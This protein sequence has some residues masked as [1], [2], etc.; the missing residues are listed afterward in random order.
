MMCCVLCYN[1]WQCKSIIAVRCSVLQCVAVCCSMLYWSQCGTHD[2]LPCDTQTILQHTATHCSVLQCGLS[3]T[4]VILKLTYCNLLECVAMCWDVSQNL[5]YVAVCGLQ[6]A[7]LCKLRVAVCCSVLQCVAVYCPRDT[8][9]LMQC[10]A[11]YWVCC[12]SN[13]LMFCKQKRRCCRNLGT[14]THMLNMQCWRAAP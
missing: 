13:T 8:T 4:L 14:D 12:T 3:I 2:M 1:V 9:R 11:G 10:V 5:Q 6:G 7:S